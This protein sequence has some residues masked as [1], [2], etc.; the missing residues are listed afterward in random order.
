MNKSTLIGILVPDQWTEDGEISGF[1]LCTN[2]EQKYVLN[3]SNDKKILMEMLH[4]TVEV[5]GVVTEY[6]GERNIIATVCCR[7]SSLEKQINEDKSSFHS[8]AGQD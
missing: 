4:Q 6:A 3:Y 5:I 8:G 1:A 2:D 7:I